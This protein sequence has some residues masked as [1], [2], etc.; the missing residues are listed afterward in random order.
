MLAIKKPGGGYFIFGLNVSTDIGTPQLSAITNIC[1]MLAPIYKL[2]HS[3]I[4]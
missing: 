4:A 3:Q 1:N 2:L